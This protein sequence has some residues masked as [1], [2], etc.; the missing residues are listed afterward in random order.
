MGER[1]RLRA[2]EPSDIEFIFQLENHIAI[3]AVGDTII[4]YSRYQ[5]EQYVLASEHDLFSE[6]QLRLMIET[7]EDGTAHNLI[8]TMDLYD[9]NPLHQ[10]AALGILIIEQEQNKGYA[11]EALDLVID[12]SFQILQLH[13]LYCTI[14]EHNTASIKLFESKKFEKCGIKKEWRKEKGI[15]FDEWM[16]QRINH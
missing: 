1:V 5:V 10:R 7:V 13:Q 14:A 2:P 6:R 16:F 8:G 3:W 15:W 4:P 9:F 11:S 12:Y